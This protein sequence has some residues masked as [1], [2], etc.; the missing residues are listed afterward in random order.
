M[1]CRCCF[2][3]V[4]IMMRNVCVLANRPYDGRPIFQQKPLS[5][6]FK[7]LRYSK[8]PYTETNKHDTEYT[9]LR[10]TIL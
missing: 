10:K 8:I 6:N 9:E 1:L 3:N 7:L 2:G 4:F 5:P